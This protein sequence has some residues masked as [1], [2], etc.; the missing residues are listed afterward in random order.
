M[1]L[2]QDISKLRDMNHVLEREK[3]IS[4]KYSFNK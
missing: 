3:E 4:L 2:E 1:E